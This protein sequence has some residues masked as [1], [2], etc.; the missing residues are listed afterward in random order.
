MGVYALVDLTVTFEPLAQRVVFG[1]QK[2]G[3]AV[4][5]PRC[6]SPPAVSGSVDQPSVWKAR[7]AE[8][9]AVSTGGAVC[10]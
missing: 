1:I 3:D 7:S 5:V 9:I 6:K 2:A 4:D 10:Q 8:R